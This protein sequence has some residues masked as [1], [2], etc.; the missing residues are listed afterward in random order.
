MYEHTT[1]DGRV[2]SLAPGH[3]VVVTSDLLPGDVLPWCGQVDVVVSVAAEGNVRRVDVLRTLD[4]TP[5][6]E[7]RAAWWYSGVRAEH[8]VIARASVL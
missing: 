7:P 4:A 8:H 6:R 1:A 5:N 2:F 3:S